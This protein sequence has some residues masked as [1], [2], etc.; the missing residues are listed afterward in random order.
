MVLE[1]EYCEKCGKKYTNIYHNWCRPCQINYLKNDFTNWTS[2]NENIDNFIREM[3]LKIE[4]PGDIIFEWIPYDQFNDIKEV[5]KGGFAT[6]YSAIWKD[7]LLCWSEKGYTRN[8]SN[9]KVALKCLNNSQ[10]FTSK[11]L[12][13]V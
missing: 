7:N 10:S 9:T 2:G 6:I 1:D 5:G 3:Q 11:L 8:N 12:N 4:Y 13:E